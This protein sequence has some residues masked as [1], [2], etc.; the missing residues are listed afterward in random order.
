MFPPYGGYQDAHYSFRF[1][2][3]GIMFALFMGRFVP[4]IVPPLC[5]VR[6]NERLLHLTDNIENTA[7]DYA[8]EFMNTSQPSPSVRAI[9][10]GDR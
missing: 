6:S 4:P 9:D 1:V 2:I 7:F 5:S 3:P 8:M 10:Q